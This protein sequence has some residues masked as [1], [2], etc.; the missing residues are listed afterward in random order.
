[1]GIRDR[2]NNI[3]NRRSI[4]VMR[5]RRGIHTV[6]LNNIIHH[7]LNTVRDLLSHNLNTVKAIQALG[8]HSRP[9][10]KDPLRELLRLRHPTVKDL[11]RG[12]IN[13]NQQP[14]RKHMVKGHRLVRIST[15]IRLRLHRLRR[16][17]GITDRVLLGIH[18]RTVKGLRLRSH[19]ICNGLRGS[20]NTDRVHHLDK[21]RTDKVHLL[22]S[23]NMDKVLLPV[24]YNMDKVLRLDSYHMDKVH[25]L[26]SRHMDRVH[27]PV[28]RRMDKVRRLRSRL[29][30]RVLLLEIMVARGKLSDDGVCE[31]KLSKGLL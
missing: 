25:H 13:S 28:N 14:H 10:V 18:L 3:I 27:L 24:S 30:G 31:W 17:Q 7:S 4:K 15:T 6:R 22:D 26:V 20:H 19:Q 21:D 8:L 29:M 5:L 2:N 11:L 12:D 23:R 9:I 1:M 16:L